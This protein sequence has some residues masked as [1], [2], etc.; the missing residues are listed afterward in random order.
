MA[1]FRADDRHDAR[2]PGCIR[3]GEAE[4]GV[5]DPDEIEL[6]GEGECKPFCELCREAVVLR[7]PKPALTRSTTALSTKAL[8]AS[9]KM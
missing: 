8:L 5:W 7:P 9:R 3:Q 1:T 6:D 2:V 4:P